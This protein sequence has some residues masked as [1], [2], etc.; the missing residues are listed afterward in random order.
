MTRFG[1]VREAITSRN[2]FWRGLVVLLITVGT[3][4]VLRWALGAAADPVP[5]VTY[6]P[7]IVLCTLFAGWRFGIASI[8]ITAAIAN[9]GFLEDP[10][11]A[12]SSI[13]AAVM[14]TLFVASC[15]LLLA[16]TQ[17]LRRT[18]RDMVAAQDRSEFLMRELQHRVR[19]TLTIV[20]AMAQ[21]SAR[22]DPADFISVF[23][24]RL[25]ALAKA[26]DVLFEGGHDGCE[27]AEIVEKSCA[28]FHEE[29]HFVFDGPPCCLPEEVCIPLSLAL[30]EL[31]T[32]ALKYGALSVPSGRVDVSWTAPV[33][34]ATTLVWEETGGP[35][36]KPPTRS[37]MGTALLS[38]PL[39]GK[40]RCDIARAG[41]VAR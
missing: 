2:S 19:N 22:G 40:A 15:L 5:F 34:E 25:S 7:A 41:S 9:W 39:L 35:E 26:H 8:L 14:T 11:R 20:Q 21:Q 24:K 13:Q 23:S 6:F 16:I 18:F 31:C 30:H 10:I 33:G 36:V 29:G 3:A 4:T 28:A 1:F 12:R 27:L 38:S 17:T 37:G 32:N